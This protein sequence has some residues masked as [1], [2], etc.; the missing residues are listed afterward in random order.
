MRICAHLKTFYA[1][2]KTK[3]LSQHSK[4]CKKCLLLITGTE[5]TGWSS[6]VHFRIRRIFVSTNQPM[7]DSIPLLEPIKT[8]FKKIGKD[9]VGGLSIAFTRKAEVDETFIGN[10]G[11][12]CLS[13]VGID[14][15][16]LCHY[17]T[18]Q[19][20]PKGLYTRREHDPE[21]NTSK[22]QQN[23]SRNFENMVMSYF[24]RQRPDCKMRVSTPQQLRKRFII[25]RQMVFAR[26][27]ML[28]L[29]LGAASTIT[30]H[31]RKHDF[32]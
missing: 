30:V 32:L 13:I 27:V 24:Q 20:M 6:S 7:P 1:S 28:C 3:T 10:S 9:K 11:S 5:L 4:Q 2:T 15:S 18:C 22:P 8:F 14:A 16:Q 25:S 31:V 23:E 29:R 19:P 26:I 21:Y 12:N 17:S